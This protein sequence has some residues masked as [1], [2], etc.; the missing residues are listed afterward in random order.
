VGG[1]GEEKRRKGRGGEGRKGRGKG[2]GKGG[3]GGGRRRKGGGRTGWCIFSVLVLRKQR[4][5]VDHCELKARVIYLVS[6]RTAR[7]T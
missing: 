6:F 3:K 1:G 4:R 5:Q 2:K 7:D